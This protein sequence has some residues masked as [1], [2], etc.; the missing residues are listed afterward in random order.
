MQWSTSSSPALKVTLNILFLFQSYNQSLGWLP[1]LP[2]YLATL[3][4]LLGWWPYLAPSTCSSP[5]VLLGQRLV[6]LGL[7][8]AG[9]RARLCPAPALPARLLEVGTGIAVITKAVARL[10]PRRVTCEIISGMK[11]YN[12]YNSYFN[13]FRLHTGSRPFLC[14]TP[15]CGASF[16]RSGCLMRHCRDVH[17]TQT[18]FSCL[19]C[20]KIF[21]RTDKF[22]SHVAKCT[23][24]AV[25]SSQ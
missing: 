23:K 22:W 7:G 24:K 5:P 2:N 19:R 11:L 9:P 12:K 25:Q 3:L 8:E 15:D 13:V 18:K 4:Y 17:G 21:S 10:S 16:V 20:D 6:K 1:P 14:S